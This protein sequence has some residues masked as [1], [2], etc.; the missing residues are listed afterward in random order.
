MEHRRRKL[1]LNFA[2]KA[3]KHSKFKTWFKPTPATENDIHK[4]IKFKSVKSNKMKLKKSPLD[5]LTKLLN[6]NNSGVR[7]KIH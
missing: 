3:L 6:E 7:S 2:K 5:Y 4:R 1:S